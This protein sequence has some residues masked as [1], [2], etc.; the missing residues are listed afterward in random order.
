MKITQQKNQLQIKASAKTSRYK[1]NK[2]IKVTA[3]DRYIKACEKQ[4]ESLVVK[5]DSLAS[6]KKIVN[7][8]T[9][10]LKSKGLNSQQIKQAFITQGTT[11]LRTILGLA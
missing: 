8:I 6:N 11:K 4:R 9:Q 10:A 1:N 2:A 7:R 3:K 5:R